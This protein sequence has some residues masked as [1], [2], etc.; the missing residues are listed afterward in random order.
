MKKLFLLVLMIS[1]A[2]ETNVVETVEKETFQQ[3]MQ[4]NYTL[5]DVRTSK[6]FAEGYINNAINIDFNSPNFNTQILTL[7]KEQPLLVYC[8][9]GGRSA[10]AASL[11]KSL[12]FKKVYEL[13]GGYN[14]W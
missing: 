11:M 5:V 7:S 4:K 8:A 9:V 3:L 14:N 2:R 6:E 13:Q 10:M 1:C 12:G